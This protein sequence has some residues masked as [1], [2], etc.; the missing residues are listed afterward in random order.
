MTSHLTDQIIRQFAEDKSL[1]RIRIT[2]LDTGYDAKSQFFDAPA[3][4][5]RLGKWRD[6]VDNQMQPC[7][8]DGHGT[9]VLSLVM[10][11]APAADICVARIAKNSEDLRNRASEVA[12]VK[13]WYITHFIS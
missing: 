7:D 9:H 11:I 8:C 13:L 5:N 10:K 4:K 12:K 6:F 2:I 3:R 1:A